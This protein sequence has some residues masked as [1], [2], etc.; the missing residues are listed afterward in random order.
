MVTFS[1]DCKKA[2]DRRFRHRWLQYISDETPI[3]KPLK[4]QPWMIDSIENKTGTSQ[5]YVPYT[6]VRAKIDSWQPPLP[7]TSTQ[8]TTAMKSQHQ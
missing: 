8:N 3:E 6:T 2:L 7:S 5:I 4:R 1:I